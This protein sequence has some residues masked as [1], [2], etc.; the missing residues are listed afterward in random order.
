MKRSALSLAVLVSLMAPTGAQA[1]PAKQYVLKH[2][3]HEHC[4]AH[5]VRKIEKV[6]RRHAEELASQAEGR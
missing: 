1:K 3:K 5:Y 6:K 4:R 2:P